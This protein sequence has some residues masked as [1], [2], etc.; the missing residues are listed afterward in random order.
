MTSSR[1]GPCRVLC[2]ARQDDDLELP[3][4]GRFERIQWSYEMDGTFATPLRFTGLLDLSGPHALA[5]LDFPV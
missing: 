2:G 1:K 3:A 5:H 4:Y